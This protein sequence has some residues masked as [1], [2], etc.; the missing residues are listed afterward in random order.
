MSPEISEHSFE[1]AVECGLLRYGPDACL[2]GGAAL[3][4]QPEPWGDLSTGGY[5]RRLPEKYDRALCLIPRDVV[6]F[7]LAIQPKE[8]LRLTEHYGAAVRE[9]FVRRLASEIE[10]RGSLD[11]LRNDIKDSSYRGILVTI[12]SGG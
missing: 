8:W 6:D 12:G 11:V 4:E 3:Q 9:R 7:V 5:R 1:D 2:E 10:R